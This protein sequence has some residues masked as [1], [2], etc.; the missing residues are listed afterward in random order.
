MRRF[1][2]AQA[3]ALMATGFPNL[4]FG[5]RSRR[6]CLPG[7]HTRQTKDFQSY[8][9]ILL[10]FMHWNQ[11][12]CCW[13]LLNL[14][15]VPMA[16]FKTGHPIV[17]SYKYTGRH[18]PCPEENITVTFFSGDLIIILT[19][20]SKITKLILKKSLILSKT[21]M[22]F[23]FFKNRKALLCYGSSGIL[24]LQPYIAKYKL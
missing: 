19:T 10:A 18:R 9:W 13:L 24:T 4:P 8:L 12:Q 1:W 23:F 14:I 2:V 17:A 7:G 6:Y 20:L 21:R 5:C 15:V 22:G 3:K 16:P 11:P